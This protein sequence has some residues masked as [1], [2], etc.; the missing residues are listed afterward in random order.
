VARKTGH[1]FEQTGY[2]ILF[3][4]TKPAVFRRLMPSDFASLS[5]G[6]RCFSEAVSVLDASARAI[7][8]AVLAGC[9]WH[10]LLAKKLLPQLDI[11]PL[12][13]VAVVGG[14]NIGKSVIFN[15]LAGENASAATPLASG[16]KHPVCLAP[17]GLD[18]PAL[19]EKL[20]APFVLKLWRS[21]EDPLE[22]SSEN[23]LFWR[24]GERMPPRL[25]VL[26]APDVDS[27]AMINW[28][29]A[30]AI[31]EAADV[32]VAILTQQKY[33]D[34]AVKRFFR[35]AADA[36][37][38]IVVLFNQC[39]LEADRD[40]WPRWLATFREE[41]GATP[42]LVYIAPHDRRAAEEL[43][44]PIHSAGQDGKSPLGEPVHLREE[45]AALHF[46][47]IKIRTFRGALRIVLDRRRG[48]P[49]YLESIR[50]ASAEFA[51][52]ADALST[53]E[54]ARVDWPS[55]PAGVLVEEIRAWWNGTREP[56]SRRIHGFY[57]VLGRGVT[58]PIRAAWSSVAGTASDPLATFQKQERAAILLA[59]GK[60]LNE[61]ERLAQVGNDTLRPRL[62]KLLSGHAR[63]DL[64]TRVA[65]AHEELPAVD[66]HYREFLRIELSAWCEGNPNAVKLLKSLD[67]LA[68]IARP[69]ISIG[70]FFTGLHLAGDLAVHA[71]SQ[72]AGHLATEAAITGGI[73]GGGEAIVGTASEGV[74]QAAGRM[75]LKLQ[76]R[77]AQQRARWLAEWLERELLGDLLAELRRG[78]EIPQ[79]D[80][81]RTVEKL[82][83]QLNEC[84]Q[85]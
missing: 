1:D 36:D 9:E 50:Q 31:R 28:D 63:A 54:M 41:T 23:R 67:H 48:A 22:E 79:S 71:A 81:F 4:T 75:F 15:H 24:R 72:T 83:Q 35:A 61:L 46:D 80:E 14:T 44:L 49:S 8:A 32:L 19:L 62:K 64:L 82:I 74:S 26:D 34:A 68:A 66:E 65:N 7:G 69:A 6:I 16:T 84:Q 29:R 20:F 40:Y 45:L 27:D 77:Y 18:D 60:L 57:R 2:K 33:N 53:R 39:D 55:L 58:W 70:L 38:P 47:A 25:L 21:P 56:W 85:P 43:R 78:A 76:S 52:A 17:E 10:D 12:L 30:K 13:V 59:V 11:P 73:A 42:E 37:K 51:A 5:A 3:K